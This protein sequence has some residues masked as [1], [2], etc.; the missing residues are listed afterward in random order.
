MVNNYDF[1]RFFFNAAQVD[2]AATFEGDFSRIVRD[3]LMSRI[4]GYKEGGMSLIN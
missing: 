3:G 4:F 2:I 1:D